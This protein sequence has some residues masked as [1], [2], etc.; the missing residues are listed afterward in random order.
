MKPSLTK[1]LLA[2]ASVVTLAAAPAHAANTFYDPG[3][4]ILFFQKP[5][6]Q[7]TV[8]VSLGSAA[9]NYRGLVA[10]TTGDYALHKTDILNINSTLTS[11]FGAGWASDT[12]I[13]AGVV[14]ARSSS[15]GTQVFV[16]DQTR[17]V[18]ASKAR[19]SV[20]SIGVASSQ[21]WDF[22]LSSAN[23]A[24]ATNIVALGNNLE[25]NTDEK[26]DIVTV[27]L[28]SIDN[29]NPFLAPGIQ[30]TAFNA[31]GGG[32]QQVG[33]SGI[34][35]TFDGVGDVE[36]ALDIYRITPR[37]NEDTTGEVFGTPKVG[38]F[39]GTLVIGSNGSV[40]YLVPEPSSVALSGLAGLA[41]ALR[42]R[43]H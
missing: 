32:I 31:F 2:S 27:D 3:D 20:G 6:T 43:R 19:E 4:L 23:T 39:E 13:Y 9:N 11:A 34:F 36:F 26:S 18:Y 24:A 8:Y 35:G 12:G 5:G 25:N 15:T 22:T 37:A 7:N 42:R 41:L 28:S 1:R 17:T 21:A 29:Q 30:D 33:G 16:G 38:S 40:S 10:G 14:A